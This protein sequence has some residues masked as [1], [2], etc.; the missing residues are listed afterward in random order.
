VL[1]QRPKDNSQDKYIFRITE[2]EYVS[3]QRDTDLLWVK[4]TPSGFHKLGWPVVFFQIVIFL[5]G[6]ILIHI[7]HIEP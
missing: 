6:T 4:D 5:D 1:Q 2:I 3:V 7:S